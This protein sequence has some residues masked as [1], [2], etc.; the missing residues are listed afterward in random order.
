MTSAD[1]IYRLWTRCRNTA[2]QE[3]HVPAEAVQLLISQ[4]REILADLGCSRRDADSVLYGVYVVAHWDWQEPTARIF[5]TLLEIELA[6]FFA[7]Q[8]WMN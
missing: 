5:E 3:G 7:E 4:S 1:A 2:Q 8:G 6:E